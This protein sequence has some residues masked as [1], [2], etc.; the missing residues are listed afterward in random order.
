MSMVAIDNFFIAANAV[1]SIS[2]E[3]YNMIEQLAR[4]LDAVA[5]T[6]YQSLYVIDY[7][8]KNFFYVSENP[9]FLCGETPEE[10][11]Q[12]GYDFYMNHVPEKE[13][14]M[15]LEINKAGFNQFQNST[16]EEKEYCTI[17]YNFHIKN[18][19]RT[20][21]INHKLTPLILTKTGRI[22]LAICVVSIPSHKKVGC[23]EMR[24]NRKHECLHYSL[25]MHQW[26]SVITETLNDNERNILLLSAQ[27]FTMES[28]ANQLNFGVNTVKFYR[29]ELFKKLHVDNIS[30]AIAVAGNYRML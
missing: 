26:T 1:E 8:K 6:T 14:S 5:R 28:I 15:L 11:K 22:W 24:K 17:S 12:Q 29:K 30:E 19:K 21:L 3:E 20:V 7:F 9:F 27:G 10:V 25:L 2:E 4:T 16:L 18:G 13:L 23:V